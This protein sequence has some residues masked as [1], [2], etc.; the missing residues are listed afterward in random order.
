M[1]KRIGLLGAL[2]ITTGALVAGCDDQ[3]IGDKCCGE[4]CCDNDDCLP[5]TVHGAA[6]PWE[7]LDGQFGAAPP[8]TLLLR[9]TSGESTCSDEPW[10]SWISCTVDDEWEALIPLPP[11]LQLAG[12]SVDLADLADLREASLALATNQDGCSI[13]TQALS[14]TLEV[15]SIDENN[16]TV[17]LSNTSPTAEGLDAEFS[18]PRCQNP[19]LPQQAVA[20]TE[21]QL[22][23]KYPTRIAG[24]DDGDAAPREP[25]VTEPLHIF[26][27]VSDPAL[28][29]Q[30]SDPRA[31]AEG[32]DPARS[33]LEITLGLNEQFAGSYPVSPT[34]VVESR[35]NELLENDTCNPV[36]TSWTSGTVE[37][38]AITPSLV[39]V[40]VDD[41]VSVVDAIATRC[42]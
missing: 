12:A 4:E 36:L 31:L 6:T 10:V 23:S 26:I 28:G 29:A 24:P 16:V 20:M 11:A 19:S 42:F 41:G 22:A 27:D 32:C 33:T 30:C 2:A 38:V 39:H 3:C 25:A 14:G 5:P 8:G 1:D 37:I 9:L 35:G 15:V 17:R 21:S 40:R 7:S 34:V 13:D 18:I